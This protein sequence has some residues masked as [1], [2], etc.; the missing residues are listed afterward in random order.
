[1]R[2][3]RLVLW[4]IDYKRKGEKEKFSQEVRASVPVNVILCGYS[5]N[6]RFL[7]RRKQK[8]VMKTVLFRYQEPLPMEGKPH[9][10]N[11]FKEI[12]F[13]YQWAHIDPSRCARQHSDAICD[14]IVWY[15]R[16]IPA[17]LPLPWLF[18]RST[19]SGLS[20]RST[21]S[22]EVALIRY[23]YSNKYVFECLP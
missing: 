3:S 6:Q 20:L 17:T 11:N 21:T 12:T 2:E 15:L 23:Y 19:K 13:R 1:M 18:V 9:K 10:C 8:H 5:L 4:C 22:K 7:N 14:C 16:L